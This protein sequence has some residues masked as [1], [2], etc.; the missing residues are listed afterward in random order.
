MNFDNNEKKMLSLKERIDDIYKQVN[1]L[2]KDLY[3]IQI[4][5]VTGMLGLIVQIIQFFI[6]MKK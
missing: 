1:E 4:L 2:T 3:K 6:S 5:F